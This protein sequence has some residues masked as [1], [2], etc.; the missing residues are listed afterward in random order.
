M[1]KIV[2][3]VVIAIAAVLVYRWANPTRAH[4]GLPD[5]FR[6]DLER[7]DK[8]YQKGIALCRTKLGVKE[9]VQSSR[10]L[11]RGYGLKFAEDFD[12][13]LADYLIYSVPEKG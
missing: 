1:K 7:T 13:C 8:K 12:K 5:W 11:I 3:I 4:E 6:K 9:P 2:V 10:E